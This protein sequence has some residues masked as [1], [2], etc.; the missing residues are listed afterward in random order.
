MSGETT[1]WN[2]QFWLHNGTAL[3]ELVGVTECGLPQ[4]TI[5]TPEITVL[6]APGQFK[7]YMAG[8]KDGGEF[9]IMMNYTP[10][11]ATD[12]LC[13]AQLGQTR[14][15]KI[16]EPAFD[17]T[18]LQQIDG[19]GVV[20][21]YKPSSMKPGEPRTAVLTLKVSSQPSFS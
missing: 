5:D 4:V 14:A 13:R 17:G 16:V 12:L 19:S 1:G 9:D 6:K 10:R 11:T 2:G 3:V 15:F 18:Q 20:V 8:L 21:G 7:Q